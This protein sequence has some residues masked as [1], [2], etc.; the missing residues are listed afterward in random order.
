MLQF[1]SGSHKDLNSVVAGVVHIQCYS[2]R[3]LFL[4]LMTK[5]TVAQMFGFNVVHHRV[6]IGGGEP[7]VRTGK[8]GG[9]NLYHFRQNFLFCLKVSI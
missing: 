4:T 5:I 1:I 2:G 8:L 9:A 3:K 6:L 7:T